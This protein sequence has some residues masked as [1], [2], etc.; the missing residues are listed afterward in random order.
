MNRLDHRLL[1]R[2]HRTIPIVLNDVTRDVEKALRR[3]GVAFVF[4]DAPKQC[5]RGIA[6]WVDS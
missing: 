4:G 2:H 1:R 3:F 5:V 6:L